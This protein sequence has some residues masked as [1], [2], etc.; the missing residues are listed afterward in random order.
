ME[1]Y[2]PHT[3]YAPAKINLGLS[4]APKTQDGYH[5]ID[6]VMHTI[7]VGDVLTIEVGTAFEL[8]TDGPEDIDPKANLVTKAYQWLLQQEERIPRIRVHLQKTIPIGSGL[9]GGSTD[10]AAILR[11]GREFLAFN[12]QMTSR[13]GMDVP[14]F[15]SGG[16]A[17]VRGYGERVSP[18]PDRSGVSVL[19]LN[20]GFPVSTEMVYDLYDLMDNQK[21]SAIDD[22]VRAW[23]LGELVDDWPNDL[24]PAAWLA[25]PALRDF[26]DYIVRGLDGVRCY[27]SGSGGTYYCVGLDPEQASWYAD[28]M[29]QRGVPWARAT[30]LTGTMIHE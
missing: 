13:V 22:L 19:L 26:K 10:A 25:Y 23:S 12:P 7:A 24:E 6:S 21:D 28:R 3:Y 11:W 20:P 14:F 29:H 4:V 16:A 1:K 8:R 5:P 27:L 18:L 30:R 9:G 15:L 2:E 17:R